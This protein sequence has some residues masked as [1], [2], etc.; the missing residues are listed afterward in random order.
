M[1]MHSSSFESP[2]PY[3][4]GDYLNNSITALLRYVILAQNTPIL[5]HKEGLVSFVFLSTEVLPP[6]PFGQLKNAPSIQ[7]Q[8]PQYEIP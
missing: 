2:K 5:L 6:H 4:F 8:M 3:L 7:I 1:M